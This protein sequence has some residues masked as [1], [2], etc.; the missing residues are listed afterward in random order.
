MSPT[1]SA[2]PAAQPGAV[3]RS[4][5]RRHRRRR[6]HG[7]RAA[8]LLIDLDG[9]RRSTT[10]WATTPATCCCRR[11]DRGWR[12]PA[13]VRPSPASAATS[14]Q[15]CC[16]DRRHREGAGWPAAPTRCWNGRSPSRPD[17]R[18]RGNDRHRPAPRPRRTTPRAAA[19]RRR[20][21]V[22]AKDTR[23]GYEVYQPRRRADA[24]RLKL[25]GELRNA[26]ERT[27][28][29]CTTSPRSTWHGRVI[30]VE[31]LVR[32][33]HPS[34]AS[35]RP[36]SSCRSAERTG[37]IRPLTEFVL[38]PALQCRRWDAGLD[39][40]VAVNLSAR[41]LL[42]SGLPED[43]DEL[44]HRVGCRPRRLELEITESALMADPTRALEVVPRLRRWASG[45]RSTTSA[46]ATRRW[47]TSGGCRSTSSRSTSRSCS[48]CEDDG[49]AV[50]VRSTSTWPTTWGSRSWP[51]AWRPS[52]PMTGCERWVATSRRATS[53]VARCPVPSC[54]TGSAPTVT[55]AS[56]PPSL[57]VNN[58]AWHRYSP[59]T[60]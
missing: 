15:S 22:P 44:L 30:G 3:P 53:S 4:R 7:E 17:A 28:S 21:H 19:A 57:V 12:S 41:D 54:S 35:C 13:R 38:G 50:I 39:L 14:S 49:D 32:W 1:P 52:T 34:R 36:T 20:R 31:A 10:R 56:A 11:S 18:G 29:S 25:A 2:H 59:S 47:R 51:R 60:F 46:P 40:T 42:D 37:L 6:P 23:T 55:A 48:T 43:I 26:I 8:V 33:Q 9:S 16:P 5:P 24:S 45:S 58:G 27:S